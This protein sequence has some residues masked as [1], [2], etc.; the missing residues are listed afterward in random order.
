MPT[1]TQLFDTA[2]LFKVLGDS[3]RIRIINLLS[4]DEFCV[5]DIA[6]RLNMTQSAISH[7]L[8]LLKASR[9]VKSKRVGQ[10]IF[11]SFYDT[12]ISDIIN[13]AIIHISED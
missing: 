9:L 6:A 13:T 12:H 4:E 2:E 1:E 5:A 3:T 10:Q 7:Q 8:R 11:Y